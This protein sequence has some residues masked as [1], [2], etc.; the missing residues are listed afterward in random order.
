VLAQTYSEIEYIIID[1]CSTD[2]TINLVRSYGERISKFISA[3]DNGLYDAINKGIQ[4]AT[5][6]IVGVLHSDDFFYNNLVVEKIARAFE[7]IEIDAVIG[8]IQFV[9]PVDSLKIVRYFSSRKFNLAKFRFGYMP[10]H[11]SFYIRRE[12]HEKLGYYKTDYKIAADYELVLR[13]LLIRKIKYRYLEMPFVSMRSGGVSNKS[14]GSNITLNRE[15]ARACRENG[16][17][18][19]YLLIYSKYI[20]KVFE[21]FG[22]KVTR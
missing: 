8:D 3:K 10:P 16:I 4:V 6:D 14:I 19:N 20:T 2:G 17:Y 5:G 11:P 22:K 18:T 21:F 9:D 13:F 1:G 12:L 15:I 7:E